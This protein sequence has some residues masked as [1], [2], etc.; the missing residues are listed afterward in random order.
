MVYR[1][2]RRG[3]YKRKSRRIYTRRK[4]QVKKSITRKSSKIRKR[5]KKKLI[6]GIGYKHII[7]NG[8][9]YRDISDTGCQTGSNPGGR[10]RLNSPNGPLY[11]VKGGESEDNV[12]NEIL[13]AEFYRRTQIPISDMKLISPCPSDYRYSGMICLGSKI[14][15]ARTGNIRDLQK[16]RY[17]HEGFAMDAWLGNWDVIGLVNDNILITPTGEGVRIDVGGA[18]RYRATGGLKGSS[19]SSEVKEIK[20]MKNDNLSDPGAPPAHAGAGRNAALVFGSMTF[21]S[22]ISSAE[23]TVLRFSDR[24]ISNIVLS[25]YDE[26]Y[27]EQIRKELITTLIARRNYIDRYIHSQATQSCSASNPPRRQQTWGKA[28]R[29]L[30]EMVSRTAQTYGPSIAAASVPAAAAASYYLSQQQ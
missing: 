18:L 23:N 2:T 6:G 5:L 17:V 1:K 24:D 22:V 30:R 26:P 13:T 11:Y 8:K 4:P 3:T 15:T 12:K 27:E 16:A 20:W 28:F 9:W 7:M 10:F 14:I 21:E 25:V 19:F 29:D